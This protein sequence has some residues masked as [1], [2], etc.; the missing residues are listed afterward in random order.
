MTG[1]ITMDREI[2]QIVAE[3]AAQK[4]AADII[5]EVRQEVAEQFH[6]MRE[7][8]K[9]ELARDLKSYFGKTEPEDHII[10][11]SQI[12]GFLDWGT[13]FQKSMMNKIALALIIMAIV[14]IGG[15]AL[16]SKFFGH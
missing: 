1:L 2:I 15:V 4:A 13:D 6:A 12:K 14:A 7:D 9:K 11:H 10:Q 8:F 5:V 16:A 3:A